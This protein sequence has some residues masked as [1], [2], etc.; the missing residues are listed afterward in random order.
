M[1]KIK[2]CFFGFI[3][4]ITPL[5][6]FEKLS[7]VYQVSYGNVESPVQIVLYFSLSCKSCLSLLKHDFP[8]IK[9]QYLDTGKIG[10]TFHID[11]VDTLTFQAMVCLKELNTEEKK[12]FFETIAQ[13]IEAKN[14]PAGGK[15]LQIT[16]EELGHPMPDLMDLRFL[17]ETKAFQDVSVFLKQ[18]DVVTDLP[19]LEIN[20]VLYEEYPNCTFIKRKIELLTKKLS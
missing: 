11:P 20:G 8:L 15:I 12:I 4:G 16:M 18:K 14:L 10:W 19:T 17:K 3:L 6:S 1:G 13:V 9:K 2:L 7:P 5:L